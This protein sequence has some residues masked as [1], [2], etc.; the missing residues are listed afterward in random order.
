VLRASNKK[1]GDR[2]QVMGFPPK[3]FMTV[4]ELAVRWER[5]PL[6]IIDRAISGKLKIL[7]SFT[8][9][10]FQ[11]GEESDSAAVRAGHVRTLFRDAYDAARFVMIRRARPPGSDKPLAIVQP[12]ESVRVLSTDVL[13]RTAEIERF[14]EEDSFV[15]RDIVGPGASTRHSWERFYV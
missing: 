15:R 12:S 6:Q 8:E 7:V 10:E 2:R 13:I 1:G 5:S 3:E 9:A 14:E 4:N 11:G